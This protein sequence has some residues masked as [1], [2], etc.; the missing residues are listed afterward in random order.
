MSLKIFE[1]RD[2]AKREFLINSFNIEGSYRF[3]LHSHRNHWELVYCEEGSFRHQINGQVYDHEAGRL[4]FIR[5]NDRHLL[6]GR[7]FRYSNIAF[8][9]AWLEQIKEIGGDEIFSVLIDPRVDSPAVTVPQTERPGLEKSIRSLL[10]RERSGRRELE[11]SLLLHRMFVLLLPDREPP[12]A[13]GDVPP[14]LAD[15]LVFIHNREEGIPSVEELVGHS[16]RCAEHVSRSFRKYLG[17]TPTGYLKEVKLNR[18][19]ELLRSTNFPVNEIRRLCSYENGNYFHRQFRERF[20]E[21]PMQYR[22]NR[23]H[24]IH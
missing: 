11:F 15:L 22:M 23:G 18:A 9:G 1:W 3:P 6:R 17:I 8:S 10:G 16:Y 2:P 13:E 21:T 19:A 7:E 4:V 5:E 24:R 20:G 14:W 12:E